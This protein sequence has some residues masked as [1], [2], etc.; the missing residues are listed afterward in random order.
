MTL[1][2]VACACKWKCL[3]WAVL[4]PV[5]HPSPSSASFVLLLPPQQAAVNPCSSRFPRAQLW[6]LVS[7]PFIPPSA[8]GLGSLGIQAAAGTLSS[9]PVTPHFR[10]VAFTL[11]TIFC[12]TSVCPPHSNSLGVVKSR[13]GFLEECFL[14]SDRFSLNCWDRRRQRLNEQ[15]KFSEPM[16]SWIE[17]C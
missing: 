15:R 10:G 5:L 2:G 17:C 9:S 6:E 3:I 11:W 1:I 8:G 14:S 13:N 16:A 4:P 12:S 7:L